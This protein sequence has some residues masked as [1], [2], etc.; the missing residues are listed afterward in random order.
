MDYEKLGV[1]LLFVCVL[2]LEVA[3]LTSP[4]GVGFCRSIRCKIGLEDCRS[5][6]TI[7]PTCLIRYSS[8]GPCILTADEIIEHNRAVALAEASAP[9]VI[10]V[11]DRKIVQEI[12]DGMGDQAAIAIY[13]ESG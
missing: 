10:Y 13:P 6:Y 9:K 1:G 12:L 2:G 7:E 5:P 4:A 8:P 3:V 11:N